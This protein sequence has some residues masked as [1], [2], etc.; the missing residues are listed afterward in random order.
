MDLN[1]KGRVA[2]VTG[3]GQGVGRRIAMQLATCADDF[4]G[5]VLRNWLHVDPA[6]DACEAPTAG[7][8]RW[9]ADTLQPGLQRN[10]QTVSPQTL[11]PSW[12]AAMEMSELSGTLAMN[13]L[14]THGEPRMHA[15]N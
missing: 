7:L 2:F 12:H 15:M 6:T 1:L 14:M 3:G 13:K 8:R 5:A 11:E 4:L 9:A 10:L